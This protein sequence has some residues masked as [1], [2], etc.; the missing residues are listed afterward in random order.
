MPERRGSRSPGAVPNPG[1][2]DRVQRMYRDLIIEGMA[3]RLWVFAWMNFVMEHEIGH[4]RDGDWDEVAPLTPKAARQAAEALA[5]LIQQTD[6]NDI[7]SLFEKAMLFDQGG[8][9]EWEAIE[10]K[11]GGR[12]VIDLPEAKA[13]LAYDFGNALASESLTPSADFGAEVGAWARDHVV[14]RG[15]Q[16]FEVTLPSFRVEYFD[17]NL[18]WSGEGKWLGAESGTLIDEVTGQAP[19]GGTM[20]AELRDYGD[21]PTAVVTLAEWRLQI[22]RDNSPEPRANRLQHRWF[23]TEGRRAEREV[24]AAVIPV[25]TREAMIRL[26]MRLWNARGPGQADRRR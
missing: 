6:S 13:D 10:R 8:Y 25:E 12:T 26:G 24:A 3:R 21:D 9:F 16:A 1:H 14:Q 15:R 22:D 11:D 17:G 23:R 20:R 5:G 18:N 7:L 19:G 4:P 2:H